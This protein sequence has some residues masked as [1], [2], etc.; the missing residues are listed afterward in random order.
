MA[1]EAGNR[2]QE[3]L[4]RAA[5]RLATGLGL[6]DALELIAAAA[7]EVTG[8]ELAVVRV[9]DP[10]A[11]ALVARAAAPT[12]SPLAAEIVGSRA[13][14][15]ELEPPHADERALIVPVRI[16]ERLVGAVEL[17]PPAGGFDQAARPLAELAAAQLA[18]TL[19]QVPDLDPRGL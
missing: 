19:R 4:A 18:L 15:D 5:E 13:R 10:E 16:G 8:A 14:P 9:L 7:S 17:L 1:V 11:G 3:I 6:R 2:P 12:D